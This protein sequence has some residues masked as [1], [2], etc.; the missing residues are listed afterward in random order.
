MD[1]GV[2]LRGLGL[3]QYERAFRDGDIDAAVLPELTA[4]DL[5]GLGVGSIGHRR[6]LLA[7]IAALRQGVLSGTI[8]EAQTEP[9]ASAAELTSVL[10]SS[11]AERRQLTV[12]FV[13]LVGSTAMSARLDPEDMQRIL[14]AYQNAVT[15]EIAKLG[16]HVAKLMGD[17]V[18]CYFGWPR[19]HEDEAERAVR[20]GLAVVAAVRDLMA[21]PG[22][23]LAARVGIATG[24]VVVG[25]LVGEGPAREEAVV[26]ETPNLAARLQAISEPGQV[27]VSADTRALLGQTFDLDDLGSQLLRGLPRPVRAFR[28]RCESRAD[29]RFE[30]RGGSQPLPMVGRDQELALLLERWRQA[31]AGEG[32]GVLLVGEAGIGKSRIARG[33]LDAIADRPHRRLRYQCSP[34]H[35]DSALWPVVRQ[36]ERAAGLEP[37]DQQLRRL[38]KLETLLGQA[39]VA[40]APVAPLFAALLGIDAEGRYPASD[41]T[42]QQRRTR[43]L[44][45]LTEQL[46]GLARERPVLCLFED[47]HWADPTTI[48]LIE[49]VVDR[50]A[51]ARVLLLL[52]ARPT[53]QHGLGGHPHVTRLTL[54]RLG[55]EATAEIV[56]EVAAGRE[57]P[58]E[59]VAQIVA[60]AD[61]VPLF[62]EELTKS[63]LEATSPTLAV[64]ATLHDSLMARL[65]PQPLVKEI[66]QVAACIGREFDRALLGAVSGLDDVRLAAGLDQLLR[67]ELAFRRSTGGTPD[68]TYVF[69][70]ALVRDAA[71]ASLLK[72]KR[73]RIHG[74][75]VEELKTGRAD[76][77][78]TQPELLARHCEEAELLAEAVAH[79]QAAGERASSRA[80]AAEAAAHFGSAVALVP[81][82]T[83]GPDRDLRE[84]VLQT[85][86]AAALGLAHGYT[87]EASGAAYRRAVEICRTA[88][89]PDE[90]RAA[91]YGLFVFHLNRA[92]L[93]QAR[94]LAEE[95]RRHAEAS[96]DTRGL[97][98][99]TRAAGTVAM[100]LG[101]LPRACRAQ[102]RAL[103][104][105]DPGR[106]RERLGEFQHDVEVSIR[107]NLAWLLLLR[108]LPDRAVRSSAE[109]LAVA[110]SL[111]HPTSLAVALHRSCQFHQLQR[112]L[113]SALDDLAELRTLADRHQLPFFSAFAEAFEGVRLGDDGRWTEA[114]ERARRAVEIFRAGGIVLLRPYLSALLGQ[115]L[116]SAGQ[117]A[118]AA[119]V[120][121][122][123][124]ERVEA[125]DER[126]FEAELRRLLGE[127]LPARRARRRGRTLLRLGPRRGA[128]TGRPLVGAARDD[129]ALPA[130]GGGWPAS[131]GARHTGSSS[132]TGSRRGFDMPDLRDARALLNSLR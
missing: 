29:S 131:E 22:E 30:A 23:Q 43:T 77:T 26:G 24:L 1:V 82:L 112:D 76:L 4:D 73:Q 52:T 9:A 40:V 48:E 25:N 111:G 103:A 119:V 51:G 67:A 75:I 12:M 39:S 27:V 127:L 17:G 125:T 114:V 87:H 15:G 132:T 33:L 94:T 84:A 71:H 62:V 32:Q 129:L 90:M 121:D 130:M 83:P 115:T 54:N 55:R 36:L 91:L 2:W 122:R 53:F 18:L 123:A 14:R 99:G 113:A 58:A 61:G 57:L 72:S 16:G 11:E 5:L 86:L 126:W 96:G 20:A 79:W 31:D 45:A 88:G 105:F 49:Q 38:D 3:E 35:V 59:L 74:R 68:S 46:L 50:I 104:L 110:R 19:A 42:P 93:V 80:A 116:M 65:D 47:V 63:V 10:R 101:D 56:G 118:E 21:P 102:E 7:A 100:W 98:I 6:K 97:L 106:D 109:A 70:H 128:A 37:D 81:R 78:R 85:S 107:S 69:K 120:L 66:A 89:H 44:A 8:Q 124:L 60:R 108:G 64:P 92:E 13:D 117:H 28:V 34:Y 95:Q 41:L